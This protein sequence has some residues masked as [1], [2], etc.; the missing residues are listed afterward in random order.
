M[1]HA[2]LTKSRIFTGLSPAD[3]LDKMTAEALK[4]AV[5]KHAARIIWK[6]SKNSLCS[7]S[8]RVALDEELIPKLFV[9]GLHNYSYYQMP[10]MNLLV[11]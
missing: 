1:F 7:G 6:N 9:L 3:Y 10:G 5:T 4:G 2:S 8:K 11:S